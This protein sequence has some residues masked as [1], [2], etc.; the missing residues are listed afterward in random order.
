MFLGSVGQREVIQVKENKFFL[1]DGQWYEV[2][3]V[4]VF[5]GNRQDCIDKMTADI[6]KFFDEMELEDNKNAPILI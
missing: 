2:P 5:K 4:Y 3:H 6:N 1:D